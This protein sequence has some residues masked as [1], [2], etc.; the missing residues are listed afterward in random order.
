MTTYHSILSRS[1]RTCGRPIFLNSSGASLI[2]SL[3]QVIIINITPNRIFIL[4]TIKGLELSIV[5]IELPW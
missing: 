5:R 1:G 4:F 2:F 3:A